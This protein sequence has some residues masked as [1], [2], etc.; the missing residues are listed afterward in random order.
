MLARE[1]EIEAATA[2]LTHEMSDQVIS[3]DTARGG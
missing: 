3:I 1:A 2:R